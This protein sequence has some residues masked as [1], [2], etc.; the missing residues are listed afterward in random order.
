MPQLDVF[1]YMSLIL[2]IYVMFL[3]LVF[4]TYSRILPYI[5]QNLKIRKRVQALK[6]I[7]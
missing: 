5:G 7:H 2:W 3:G 4:F 6:K 1:T